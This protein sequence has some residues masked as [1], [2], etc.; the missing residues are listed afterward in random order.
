MNISLSFTFN[1][2]KLS[3]DKRVTCAPGP[4]DSTGNC[5]ANSE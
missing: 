1:L 2:E 3:L 5:I 4:A